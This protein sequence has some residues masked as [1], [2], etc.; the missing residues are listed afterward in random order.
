MYLGMLFSNWQS[1]DKIGRNLM[2]NNFVF[3]VKVVGSWFTA[4][5]YIWTLIVPRLFLDRDFRIE[6]ERDIYKFSLF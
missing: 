1:T 3:W 5:V 6:W 4:L 2:G